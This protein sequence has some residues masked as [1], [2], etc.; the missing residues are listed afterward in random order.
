MPLRTDLPGDVQAAR[1]LRQFFAETGNPDGFAPRWREVRAELDASGTYRASFA[2]LELAA[3]VAWRNAVRCIGRL[4]WSGLTVRDRRHLTHPDDIAEAL[5]EHLDYAFN[6]GNLRPALTVLDPGTPQHPGPRIW[7]PQLVRYAGYRGP[8]RTIVGD[9][10]QLEITERIMQLGWRG[11][12]G[13]FDILPLVIACPGQPPRW[14]EVPQALAHEVAIVHPG[15]PWLERLGLRWYAVPAVADMALDAGGITYRCVPYNGW[16]MGTEIAARNLTD[17]NRYDLLPEIAERMGLDMTS[18]RTLWRDKAMIMLN[19]AVLLSY[20]RAGVKIAD[21]HEASR[22]FLDFCRAEQNAG[23]EPY[24]KWM[25]LVPPISG[26][27][28]PLYQ[29]PFQ[30]V[31]FKPAF[32]HQKPAWQP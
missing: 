32:R 1:F 10:A 27:A 31:S 12:G 18:E 9:P 15:Y 26:S 3:R 23:R 25:W 30:D 11:G 21:H 4:Y 22:E 14:Y 29:E 7:N 28:T 8:R 6:G 13:R 16:Y 20:D 24:G 17:A 2:E 5:F 19:E